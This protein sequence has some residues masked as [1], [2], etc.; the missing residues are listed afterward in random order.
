[1]HC[2]GIKLMLNDFFNKTLS[3]VEEQKVRGHLSECEDCR[4]E[5]SR[6]EKAD[7]ALKK[8]IHEMVAGIEVPKSLNE[9]IE[10]ALAMEKRPRRR[11]GFLPALVRTPAVA[12]ALLLVVLTAGL[13]GYYNLYSPPNQPKV[14][15]SDS[16]AVPLTAGSGPSDMDNSVPIADEKAAPTTERQDLQAGG[17]SQK[18]DAGLQSS[19]K[20][21]AEPEKP[22]AVQPPPPAA[23]SQPGASE[24][25][26][27]QL[28]KRPMS[29]TT[30]PPAA[31]G[32]V[33]AVSGEIYDSAAGDAGFEPLKPTYL[34][35][36]MRLVDVSWRSGVAYQTYR[37]GSSYVIISQ[38][39]ATASGFNYDQQATGGAL[40]SINGARAVLEENKQDAS[41]NG[42]GVFTVLR[43]QRGEWI[44]SV[45]GELTVDEIIKIACSIG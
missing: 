41:G 3:G 15:I 36:G 17:A 20:P 19:T 44:F 9:R 33:K 43:W 42:S 45:S 22:S 11:T 12:A 38:G 6:L 39:R 21:A 8:V 7:A 35:S 31:G 26:R 23:A 24:D 14:A 28:E 34:P 16:P 4:C 37:S 29:V 32:G 30:A 10:M 40:V 5:F 13:F 1:M 25:A 18:K 27:A 2:D